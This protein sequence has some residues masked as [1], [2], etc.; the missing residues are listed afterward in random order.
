LQGMDSP[1]ALTRQLVSRLGLYTPF[2][3]QV[4]DEMTLFE[5]EIIDMDMGKQTKH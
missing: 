5:R 1:M 4:K 2:R 3:L